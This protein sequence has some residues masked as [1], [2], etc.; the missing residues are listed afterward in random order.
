[1]ATTMLPIAYSNISAQP[2]IQAITSPKAAYAYVYALPLIGITEANSAYAMAENPQAIAVK[3]NNVTTAGPPLKLALPM[4]LKIPA[5]I[6][7]AIPI[8]VR[9]LKP[10]VLLN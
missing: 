4:V 5:P 2:I 10:K 1:M 8:A 6:I 7:A 3:I 9:S